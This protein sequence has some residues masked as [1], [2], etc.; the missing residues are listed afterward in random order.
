MTCWAGFGIAAVGNQ[1]TVDLAP[2][3]FL[4]GPASDLWPYFVETSGSF[5]SGHAAGAVA[6]LGDFA[7]FYLAWRAASACLELSRFGR[8]TDAFCDRGQPGLPGRALTWSDV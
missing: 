1:L 3:A 4:I 2:K 5:R 8:R 6:G 7:V